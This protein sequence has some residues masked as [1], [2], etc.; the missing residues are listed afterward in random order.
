MNPLHTPINSLSGE[1]GDPGLGAGDVESSAE[2]GIGMTEGRMPS[3]LLLFC[4]TE[5]S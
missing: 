5:A 4:L 1:S 3:L 2:C